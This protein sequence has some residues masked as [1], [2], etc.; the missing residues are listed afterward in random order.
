[1]DIA[2]TLRK[3][4]RVLQIS[5]KPNKEEFTTSGKICSIGMALIGVIGFVIFLIF[6]FSGI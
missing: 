6:A 4:W 2:G 3:Y 5:R 1:M